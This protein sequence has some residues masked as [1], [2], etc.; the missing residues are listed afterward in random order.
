MVDCSVTERETKNGGVLFYTVVTVEFDIVSAEDGSSHTIC[1]VGE[2]M[3][4]GD[5]STNKSQSAAYKY[6]AMMAFCIPIEG[7][8]DTENQTHE[9]A[10]KKIIAATRPLE[11]SP[12]VKTTPPDPHAELKDRARIFA[13]M[14]D[15]AKTSMALTDTLAKGVKVQADLK[16]NLPE[17]SDRL[18]GKITA[19]QNE[20]LQKEQVA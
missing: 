5:K 10:P 8:N 19:K 20:L 2:A 15:S 9:V 17:W 7:D 18:M 11:M 3:D 16:Q 14:V 12:S 1:T 13:D 4:S 6:A